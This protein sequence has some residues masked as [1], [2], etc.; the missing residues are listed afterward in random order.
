MCAVLKAA[1]VALV[2][3]T[4]LSA[5]TLSASQAPP[6]TETAAATA[7]RSADAG[8]CGAG[9]FAIDDL[10]PDAPSP[11]TSAPAPPSGIW[12][13]TDNSAECGCTLTF[14]ESA[15]GRRNVEP[16][17]CRHPGIAA[18]RRYALGAT[19]DGVEL[20]LL[21]ADDDQVLARLTRT[22]DS[23]YAG[24]MNGRPVILWRLPEDGRQR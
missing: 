6:L 1:L 18:S 12:A 22:T 13:I 5:C 23:Y 8:V 24:V 20:A 16:A 15:L 17:G 3:A 19:S 4:A 9:R 10:L 2:A 21:G 7:S 11:D 14:S